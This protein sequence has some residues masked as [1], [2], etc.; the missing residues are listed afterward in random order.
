ML[1]LPRAGRR[2]EKGELTIHNHLWN[3]HSPPWT[4][5]SRVWGPQIRNFIWLVIASACWLSCVRVRAFGEQDTKL[6][7]LCAGI[8]TQAWIKCTH[9]SLEGP[10][11]DS[12]VAWKVKSKCHADPSPPP[13]QS[14]LSLVDALKFCLCCISAAAL[15]KMLM[16]WDWSTI[17][18]TKV[19]KIS[20]G[21]N[22]KLVKIGHVFFLQRYKREI[23]KKE[24]RTFSCLITARGKMSSSLLISCIVYILT[25]KNEK[26]RNAHCLSKNVQLEIWQY[27]LFE[28]LMCSVFV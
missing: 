9:A 28:S 23:L 27:M 14:E 4:Q 3:R 18:S 17:L 11:L 24:L 5:F 12:T 22:T 25:H 13:F 7:N 15:N 21:W 20:P 16:L 10:W 26:Y 2:Q 19:Q 8:H 1:C 6:Q